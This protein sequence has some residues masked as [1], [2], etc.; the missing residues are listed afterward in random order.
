[1]TRHYYYIGVGT[2]ITRYSMDGKSEQFTTLKAVN[3]FDNDVVGA[4]SDNI[5]FVL[6]DEAKPWGT[7][8]VDRDNVT[9]IKVSHHETV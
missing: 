5:V 6:P 9:V 2:T 8:M 3:L 1:M 4:N 7:F